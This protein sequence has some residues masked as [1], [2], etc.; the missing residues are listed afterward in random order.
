[1]GIAACQAAYA[2]GAEWL[3]E[4]L[5]YLAENMRF[6][7]GF[8]EERLPRVKLVKPQGT[9]LAWLDFSALGLSADELDTLIT[10]KARLWLNRGDIFGAG[11]AGFQRLNAACPRALLR[12]ALERLEQALK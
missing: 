6:I 9:Y 4:L 8:L 11:G 7:D 5:L 1:M 2:E 3:E 12:Q 10:E